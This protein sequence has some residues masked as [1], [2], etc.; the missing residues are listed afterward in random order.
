MSSFLSSLHTLDIGKSQVA[1]N[2]KQLHMMKIT[3]IE[4]GG[5]RSLVLLILQILVK[6]PNLKERK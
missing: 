4:F 3:F 1:E 6:S 2:G 5:F